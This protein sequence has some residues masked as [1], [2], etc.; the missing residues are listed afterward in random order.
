VTLDPE[1][2]ARLAAA[3]VGRLAT[4]SADGRPHLVPLCYAIAGGI[5][6]SIV[7]DKPKSTRTGLRRLRNIEANPRATL[8]ADHYDEDWT[9]LWFVMA[10]CDA[11]V[12]SDQRE[13]VEALA[14]LRQKYP[15]YEAMRL[16]HRT[17][18]MIRLGVRRLVAWRARPA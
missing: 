16:E 17:H 10:E 14:A 1:A 2:R 11:S 6:F 7:D 9:S 13:Y 18:P 15:Q 8:L 4:A 12:V 5:A 3:R